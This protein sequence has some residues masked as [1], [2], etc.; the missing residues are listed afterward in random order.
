MRDRRW[1][2]VNAQDRVFRKIEIEQQAATMTVFRDVRDAEFSAPPCACARD[3]FSFKLR[4]ARHGGR[5]Y[6]PG[7]R[8]N[9]FGLAVALDTRDADN[10]TRADIKR[11]II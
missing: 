5:K 10:L 1:P 8:F 2:V 4:D 6:Q 3:I 7:Q 9:Q 11:N